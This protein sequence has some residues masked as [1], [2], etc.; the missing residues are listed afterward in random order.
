MDSE[1][2]MN[3]FEKMRIVYL[4]IHWKI[5]FCQ[6][7]DNFSEFLSCKINIPDIFDMIIIIFSN[8]CF[9]AMY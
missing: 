7:I 3:L 9:V 5:F 8:F 4:I 1:K 6:F 2:S